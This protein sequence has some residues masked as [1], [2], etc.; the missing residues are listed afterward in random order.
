MHLR[1]PANR[2]R[3]MHEP[4]TRNAGQAELFRHPKGLTVLFATE[5]WERFSYY[6]MASLLVL[7]LVKYLLLPGQVE[8]VIGYGAVKR[9]LE[10]MFGPLAPQSFASQVYGFY[11]GF[12]YL[13]PVFGGYL[14]DRFFGQRTMAIIGALLLAAG[15]FPMAV[16]SML[17]IALGLLVVGM[18]AFKPNVSTQVGSLYGPNDPRR[19]PAYSIYYVGINIGAL[20]APLVAG[21]LGGEVGWHYGFAA[22]GVGMLISLAM[23]LTGLK[24]LP[25]DERR[26]SEAAHPVA[27]EADR[28]EG[29]V[30]G[31][32][33]GIFLLSGLFWAS[34]EQQSNTIILWAEDFTNRHIDLGFWQGDFPTTWFLALNPLMIFVL[35]PLLIKVWARQVQHGRE[36]PTTAKLALGFFLVG[37][38]YLVMAGAAFSLDTGT[39][40]SP[41][42]LVVYVI[43]LTLGELHVG[44]VG[45]AL[46][47]RMAP[48]RVLSLMMGLWL[49]ASFPGEILGGWL[50]GFW[51]SMEKAHFFLMI[52]GIAAAGGA[53]VFA[54]NP[55]LRS[56]FDETPPRHRS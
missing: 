45:L 51:S 55:A 27:G 35:T 5:M 38:A 1:E 9:A 24:H 37:L 4:A 47:S 34:Y 3:V 10:G 21:T 44:P 40:A 49:A 33:F 7:Y 16:E 13:L 2:L 28:R 18:G 22:A 30:I 25:P 26:A 17:F 11:A 43:V 39:K 8:A 53:A 41:L 56:V 29:V 12:A 36:M 52:A 19:V 42:W 31:G 32:L 54:L 46:V 6:G 14:A 23:Y 50:G 15:H 20:L 48:A